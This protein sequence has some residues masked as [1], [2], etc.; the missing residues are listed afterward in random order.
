MT[1]SFLVPSVESLQ[2]IIFAECVVIEFACA[3]RNLLFL[4]RIE[5]GLAEGLILVLFLGFLP[6]SLEFLEQF[7]GRR[8]L[9][10]DLRNFRLAVF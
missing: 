9:V 10:E 2:V 5:H 6:L 8:L 7:D 3:R 4:L 1:R